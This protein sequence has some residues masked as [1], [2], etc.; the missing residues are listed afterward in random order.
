MLYKT[1]YLQANPDFEYQKR[2]GVWYKRKKGSKD[3]WVN[4]NADGVKV[5]NNVYK[6]KPKLFFYSKTGLIGGVAVVGIVGYLVY[7]RFV[8]KAPLL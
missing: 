1:L 5:L 2:N 8:K 6:D 4:P 7:R 3:T